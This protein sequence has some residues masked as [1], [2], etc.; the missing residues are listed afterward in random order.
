[1]K[2]YE[3][4][5]IR[6][7]LRS[8]GRSFLGNSGYRIEFTVPDTIKAAGFVGACDQHARI[9]HVSPE[10]VVWGMSRGDTPQDQFN[11]TRGVMVHEVGHARFTRYDTR[12]FDAGDKRAFITHQVFNVLEDERIERAMGG[13]YS[14]TKPPLRTLAASMAEQNVRGL[15]AEHEAK[16]LGARDPLLC[17]LD[18]DNVM[19]YLLLRQLANKAGDANLKR[20]TLDAIELHPD[21]VDLRDQVVEIAERSYRADNAEQVC[22]FA[23][24]IVAL[25]FER[26]QEE[27]PDA[28]GEEGG[29]EGSEGEE[30]S[31]GG[32]AGD[33]DSEED[34]DSEDD[35]GG[36]GDGSGS[37]E[38]DADGDEE[39]GAKQG[40][41]GVGKPVRADM[42]TAPPINDDATPGNPY[43]ARAGDPGEPPPPADQRWDPE[44]YDGKMPP[45]IAA[46]TAVQNPEKG[47]GELDAGRGHRM[48]YAQDPTDLEAIV[49]PLANQLA[50]RLL[51]PV[52]HLPREYGAYGGR[53]SMRAVI[54]T[55]GEK[56]FLSPSQPEP[57]GGVLAIGFA[58]DVS[59]SM[60]DFGKIEMAKRALGMMH[61]VC[62]EFGIWH[63]ADTFAQR[64]MILP[65]DEQL[66][67]ETGLARI[68]GCPSRGT[69]WVNPVCCDLGAMLLKRPEPVKVLIVIHDGEPGDP[70]EAA[71]SLRG[72]RNDGIE[73]LGVG[74]ML[75]GGAVEAMQKMFGDEFIDC[76][77]AEDLPRYIGSAINSLYNVAQARRAS[78]VVRG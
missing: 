10:A 50:N 78:E 22:D 4:P 31:E 33:D 66:D 28:D 11:V 77:K 70:E 3:W 52:I 57:D 64:Y 41:G 17:D 26:A 37:D 72:L 23:E 32:G 38:D 58:L 67:D 27:S 6:E 63:M 34:S 15:R 48:V 2:W 29:E 47:D 76:R 20:A 53:V 51:L 5:S 18:V 40:G 9:V 68:A 16:G 8:Y 42:P 43:S 7:S 25:L 74:I 1:M 45:E 30:E 36:D 44:E 13:M 54:R 49:R 69:T 71:L 14:F 55:Q 12:R 35:S 65:G 59:T 46:P 62:N 60:H 75:G 73:I 61:L 19:R 21:L 39:G 24:E 56:P